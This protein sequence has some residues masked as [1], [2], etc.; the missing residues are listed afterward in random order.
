M[1]FVLVSPTPRSSVVMLRCSGS[2]R[3]AASVPP[4][5]VL[6]RSAASLPRVLSGEFPALNGTISRLRLLSRHPAELRCLRLAVPCRWSC[7]LPP[8]GPRADGPGRLLARRPHRV[9]NKER[10]SPPRF[11]GDPC[12]HALL[13]DP[14]GVAASGHSIQSLL[15][16]AI[17]KTSAPHGQFRGSITRP[18]RSLCTLRRRGRPRTTQHSVPVDGQSLP[19][20]DLHPTGHKKRFQ[21]ATLPSS[22][23]SPSSRLRL[24][25]RDYDQARRDA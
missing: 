20:R 11:L 4:E 12:I 6:D 1:L 14:G 7:S 9:T 19:A 24:A 2:P 18:A 8:A 5:D 23:P 10:M 15:P 22:L 21:V 17:P 25:Q 3:S 13:S 16:S